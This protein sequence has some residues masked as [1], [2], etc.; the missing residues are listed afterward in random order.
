[1]IEWRD[2][3]DEGE[4]R[5]PALAVRLEVSRLRIASVSVMAI[6]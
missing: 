1:M 5:L 4:E 2:T 6:S 3:A